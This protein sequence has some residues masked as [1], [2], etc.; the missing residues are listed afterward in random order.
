MAITLNGIQF[1]A[2]IDASSENFAIEFVD[3]N[4]LNSLPGYEIDVSLC[5]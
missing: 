1:S 4:S 5:G 2:I 3:P